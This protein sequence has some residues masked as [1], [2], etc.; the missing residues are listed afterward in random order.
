M[1]IRHFRDILGM[2]RRNAN[3]ILAANKRKLYPLVDDKLLTKKI[4]GEHGIP[5]PDT[6]C[7][8]LN[9]FQTHLL[10]EIEHRSEFVVKP[11]RGSQGRGIV[12][13][14]ERQ[15]EYWKTAGGQLLDRDDIEYHL[16]NILAGLYSLGGVEDRAYVEYLVKPHGT[17]VP[18]LYR[19]IPDVRIVLYKGI[20]VMSMLRLPTR[21]SHGKANLH[22]GA[23]GVGVDLSTGKTVGG[24]HRN[25]IIDDHPDTKSPIAGFVV[26]AWPAIIHTAMKISDIIGLGYFGVDFVIDAEKGP[27]MLELNARPGLAIQIANREGLRP[28]LDYVDYCIRRNADLSFDARLTIMS[29][30][31][32]N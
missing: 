19:G 15:G 21:Q 18:I 10:N 1:S 26:P 4:L 14:V 28:R 32:S 22:Q 17:F 9:P 3:Y 13:I 2:N 23:I 5:M 31:A 8:I 25:R 24:V 29:E 20:P 30:M 6:Y 12:V 27:L 11:A 7:E 16:C